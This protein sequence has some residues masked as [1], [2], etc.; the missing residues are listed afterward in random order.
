MVWKKGMLLFGLLSVAC[1]SNANAA[2]AVNDSRFLRFG[3]DASA[4]GTG[5]PHNA[6][7]RNDRAVVDMIFN[8]LL[9]YKPGEAP[10]IEP[11]LALEVPHPRLEAGQQ[12]WTFR[13]RDDIQCQPGPGTE[14]YRLTSEDV[15]YSLQRSADAS[16]S[17]YAGDYVGMSFK[18]IDDFTVEIVLEKPLSSILFF[19]KVTDYAGGFIVCKR[20]VEALGDEGFASHPVGTGPFMFAEREET[21]SIRLVANDNYFRGRPRLNGV[22][23]EYLPEAAERTTRLTGKKL[24]VIFGS[25]QSQ[26]LTWATEQD[27]VVVDIFGVGQVITLHFNT[28]RAPF[29]DE[30]LRKAVVSALDRGVFRSHFAQGVVEDVYSPVPVDFLPGGLTS[31]EAKRLGLDFSLDLAKA[32]NLL[33]EAG[34]RDGFELSLVTSERHHYLA[35]YESLKEQLAAIGVAVE[36]EVVEHREMHRRIR[37][38]ENDIVIYVAWRPNADA[39]L[40]RF[41]HSDSVVVTGKSPDTNFSHYGK[42]DR[43]IEA[44]RA[45]KEPTEQVRM[46]K[47]AQVKLLSEAVAYPLHYVNLVYARRKGVTYGHPLKAAMAL[48]P[49][50]NEQTDLA[51]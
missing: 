1:A 47:Q 26:W 34:M 22:L 49:Q 7:A 41:F 5:D 38:D 29:N 32:R 23:V 9:R 17:A 6:A 24:D 31:E 20:A 51:D 15:V 45:S 11:D 37:N 33:Q 21:G 30:R 39:F 3:I 14:A 4:L 48:Y 42:I 13:L 35:N 40:T 18:A 16:R 2:E 19:P 36:L 43:L 50:F 10:A 12:V 27:D 44:A 8:G 28:A 25:E 46:W